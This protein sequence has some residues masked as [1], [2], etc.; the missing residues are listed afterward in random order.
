MYQ[1]TRTW[2]HVQKLFYSPLGTETY[3]SSTH[4]RSKSSPGK[5]GVAMELNLHIILLYKADFNMNNKHIG[6]Y[7]MKITEKGEI[8]A[9]EQHE[10]S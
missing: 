6:R 3:I 10:L 2:L 9:K 1:E 7:M 5:P 4:L 8:L